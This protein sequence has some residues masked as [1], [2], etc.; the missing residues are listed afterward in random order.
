MKEILSVADILTKIKEKRPIVHHITNFVTMND[1]ANAVLALGG[2]PIMAY[3]P[4]EVEEITAIASALVL[5]AGAPDVNRMEA[6][7]MAG[8]LANTQHIPI[9]LDPVGVGVSSFRREFIQ[10]LIDQVEI[11]VIKGNMAEIR[12]LAGC[13]TAV[14]G[15]IDSLTTEDDDPQV[16]AELA[17]RKGCI[18][19]ASGKK[20]ILSDG[21][22]I[23]YIHNGHEM[24]SC[25]TGTGCMTTS[26]MGTFIG[27]GG[28]ILQGVIGGFLTM[29]IAGEIAHQNL[30]PL[31]GH[32]TYRA[33]VLDAIGV[34]S[35]D[36]L[37]K[38]GV[39]TIE[40]AKNRL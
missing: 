21:E 18:V 28:S 4:N 38:R 22:R 40:S 15:G 2:S 14:R 23:F 7:M 34:I 36:I 13:K 26:V 9:V 16:V 10:E 11:S 5:N 24:L 12:C 19:A 6:M 33:R 29:G 27:A 31:D 20:D 1:C 32:G 37:I 30:Q 35:P 25:V 17:R 39:L 8:K 3:A